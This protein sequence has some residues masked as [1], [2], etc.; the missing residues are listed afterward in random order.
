MNNKLLSDEEV[1][2]LIPVKTVGEDKFFYTTTRAFYGDVPHQYV[3]LNRARIVEMLETKKP[4]V[5]KAKLMFR[6]EDGNTHI[7]YHVEE[8]WVLGRDEDEPSLRAVC[9][10]NDLSAVLDELKDGAAFYTHDILLN[11]ETKQLMP[12]ATL[13][14]SVTVKTP[15]TMVVTIGALTFQMTVDEWNALKSQ[16]EAKDTHTATKWWSEKYHVSVIEAELQIDHLF[17]GFAT[18]FTKQ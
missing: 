15:I 18:F 7:P 16:F 5:F 14:K 4:H 3:T 6:S 9:S 13:D 10:L 1:N 12:K 8:L 11:D 17:S 2:D